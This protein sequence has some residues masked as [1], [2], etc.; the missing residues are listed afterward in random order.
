MVAFVSR[1][2]SPRGLN[3][4]S[5]SLILST[6][7]KHGAMV[8]DTDGELGIPLSVLAIPPIEIRPVPSLDGRLGWCPITTLRGVVVV[9]F[10][11]VTWFLYTAFRSRCHMHLS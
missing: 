7:C 8:Q 6:G 3:A 5:L 2:E 10:A 11:T 1:R 4:F 9:I